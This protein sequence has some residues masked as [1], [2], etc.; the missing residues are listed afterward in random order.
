MTVFRRT[1]EIISPL[2]TYEIKKD[3]QSGVS[4]KIKYISSNGTNLAK[5]VQEDGQQE[6][7]YFYH[8]DLVG[9]IRAITDINGIVTASYEYEPFGL[10]VSGTGTDISNIRFAGKKADSTGL[11]YFGARYYDPNVGRFISRDVSRD[12]T[13][14]FVYCSNNPLA[15]VDPTGLTVSWQF[16]ST[17][18]SRDLVSEKEAGYSPIDFFLRSVVKFAVLLMDGRFRRMYS[19]LKQSDMDFRIVV[20]METGF[21]RNGNLGEGSGYDPNRN[22]I[23]WNPLFGIPDTNIG[24]A[25][26]F[27]HEVGHAI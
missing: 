11:S 24:T 12:G 3:F 25:G 14:W 2:S 22:I 10:V 16:G 23:Y 5:I 7:K 15:A 26:A 9:S 1:P 20:C 4:T 18:G 19:E 27:W 13:N 17:P 21:K 6:Q 8:V